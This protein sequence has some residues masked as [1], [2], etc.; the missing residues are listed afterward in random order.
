[1]TWRRRR[2]PDQ[3]ELSIERVATLTQRVAVLLS[4][5]VSPV[6]VWGYL[7]VASVT[8]A[9]EKAD[10][11]AMADVADMADMTDMASM[12]NITRVPQPSARRRPGRRRTAPAE[13]GERAV[14]QAAAR[15]GHRGESVADAIAAAAMHLD[16]QS[17]TSWR[18][19]AAAWSVATAA[20]APLS[21]CLRNLAESF[22]ELGQVER[23]LEVALAGP[24]S[25][26]RMVMWLPAIG[27]VLGILMGFNVLGTLLTTAPGLFC[28]AAGG[29]LMVGGARWNRGLV[30]AAGQRPATPGLECDLMA[31]AMSGGGSLAGA[32]E[33]AHNVAAR[34]GIATA[35]SDIVIQ[36]VLDLSERAGVPAA[37]LLRSEAAHQRLIARTEGQRKAATLA[38]TLM[39]P[40]G[41]CILPSFMLVGVAPLLISIVSSTFD[42][43]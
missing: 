14:V 19:I 40:L 30:R 38:V 2:S 42:A 24:R 4:A 15:A 26:A 22:R 43:L 12:A 18:G 17:A 32:R 11:A 3:V 9:T 27:I 8:D 29:V 39:L 36:S 34:F 37:E 16:E 1:M 7:D 25:T 35:R 20:G 31:I 13:E 6:S 23:E 10:R 28:L 33:L 21:S 41:L 5:G